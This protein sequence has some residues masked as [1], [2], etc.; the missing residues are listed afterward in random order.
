M[1]PPRTPIWDPLGHGVD[2]PLC[3]TNYPLGY[4]LVVRTNDESVLAAAQ[5]SWGKFEP[6]FKT[7]PLELRVVVAESDDT[8]TPLP[9]FRAQRHLLVL[10]A[11]RQNHAVCDLAQGFALCHVT[12]AVASNQRFLRFHYL[13]GIVYTTL[14]HR[15]LTPLQASCVALDGRGLL[16]CGRPGSGKSTL[17]Y[18]CARDGLAFVSDDVS[19][20][21]RRD[22]EPEIL[23]RPYHLRFRPS[24]TELF[25][26]IDGFE[27]SKDAAGESIIEIASDQIDGLQ[28]LQRCRPDRIV[29]ME[30]KPSHAPYIEPLDRAETA[31]RLLLDLPRFDDSVS[32]DQIKSLERLSARGSLLIEYNTLQEGVSTIRDLL[33]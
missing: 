24:A 8:E 12:R 3:N 22:T 16:L 2:L 33:E 32:A 19:F 26:E 31:R 9:Q 4:P 11:G 28:T 5:A 27:R 18:A 30:R 15:D 13:E 7:P 6:C 1:T 29:F 23:G 25:P 17:A 21:R 14:A 10:A 20:L